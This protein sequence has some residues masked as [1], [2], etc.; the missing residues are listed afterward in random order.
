MSYRQQVLPTRSKFT[1]EIRNIVNKF[2]TCFIRRIQYPWIVI[3]G[4]VRIPFGT[5][6]WSP[7]KDVTFGHCVQ[8]GLNC[9][10]SCDIEFGNY[11]LVAPN[12]SFIGKDDHTYDLPQNLIWN[13]PR[14]D[15]FK[16]IIGNDVWI[17]QGAIILAGVKIGNGAIIAAGSVV[18]KDVGDCE[19]VGGNPAKFIKYRFMNLDDVKTHTDFL[20][21]FFTKQK[22][23]YE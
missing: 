15:S 9:S 3:N 12:V 6:I 2:R 13:N 17:G 4:F 10:I 21:N 16:T 18:I 14:G 8:L 7:H 20:Q 1:V 5:S 22:D 23:F 19:V 11:I